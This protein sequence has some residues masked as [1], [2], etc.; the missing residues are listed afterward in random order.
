M[1]DVI[2]QESIDRINISIVRM[3]TV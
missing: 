3:V 1:M 2:Y